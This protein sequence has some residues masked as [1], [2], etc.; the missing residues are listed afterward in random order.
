MDRSKIQH[1]LSILMDSSLYLSTP[2]RERMSLLSR[3][4]KSY[5]SLFVEKVDCVDEETAMGYESSWT[6]I[7]PTHKGR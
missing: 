4:S 7:F 6:G 2:L 1:L 5:P 3:L